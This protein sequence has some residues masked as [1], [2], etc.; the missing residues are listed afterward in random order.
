MCGERFKQLNADGSFLD[1]GID[2]A[3]AS[4]SDLPHGTARQD[5][6]FGIV[7]NLGFAGRSIFIGFYPLR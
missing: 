7:I 5:V 2:W 6:D 4:A 3:N 1:A